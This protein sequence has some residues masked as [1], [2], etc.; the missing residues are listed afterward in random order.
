MSMNSGGAPAD[1]TTLEARLTWRIASKTIT[2]GTG[3]VPVT[4]NLFA[5][6]GEVEASCFGFI[7]T[8]VTAVGA[9]TLEL[10]VTG[11]TATLTAITAKAQLAIN[12]FWTDTT[13][14]VGADT[15]TDPVLISA[16][17]ILHV[18]RDSDATAGAITYYCKW[19]PIST[20]GNVVA[21]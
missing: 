6:T 12:R 7:G 13:T 3:A 1:L 16:A 17:N 19:R 10:G 14:A 9:L 4:E 18:I 5:V 21:V 20:D 8:A 11:S 2:L 15:Q